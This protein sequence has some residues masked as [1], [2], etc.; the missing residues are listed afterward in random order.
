MNRRFLPNV[1]L[2]LALVFA[3]FGAVTHAVS[4]LGDAPVHRDHA[5]ADSKTCDQCLAY[6]PVGGGLASAEWSFAVPDH[7]MVP[8]AS[9]AYFF[10]S[11]SWRFFSSRAP[12]R[13]L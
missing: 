11:H 4:H 13:T 5:P 12:P 6:A 9:P 2:A 7:A 10:F 8:V 3:Q 1:L